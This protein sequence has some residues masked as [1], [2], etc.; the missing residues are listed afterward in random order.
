MIIA[1]LL[2]DATLYLLT[3]MMAMNVLRMIAALILVVLILLYPVMI[4]MLVPLIAV[5]LKLDANMKQENVTIMTNV[6]PTLATLIMAV[7]T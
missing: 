3:V 5:T 1:V 2:M 4:L 7:N 6:L